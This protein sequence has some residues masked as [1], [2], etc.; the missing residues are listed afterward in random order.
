MQAVQAGETPVIVADGCDRTG[1]ATWI[2]NQ[3]IKENAANFCIGTLTDKSLFEEINNKDLKPGTHTGPIKVGGTTDVF[4]GEPVVLNDAVIEFIDN[5]HIVLLFG[6]NNRIVVTPELRQ[7]TTPE[8]HATIGIKFEELDIIVHKTRVHFFRGYYETGI[9]GEEY[10]GT[11][12][13]I[14]VPGW[15]PADIR[16]ITYKN[17]GQYL[18]PNV[19]DREIG[20]IWDR[21]YIGNDKMVYMTGEGSLMKE[22]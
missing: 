17:G 22:K 1:G 19:M 6:N 15:G 7:I 18:Y 5:S 2:T 9:A 10:P 8:W 21:P 3:L 11:I 4:S 12:V 20:H 13:K 16:K 14:E